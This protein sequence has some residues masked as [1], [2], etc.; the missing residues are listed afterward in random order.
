MAETKGIDAQVMGTPVM[1]DVI[2][3]VP[4][5]AEDDRGANWLTDFGGLVRSPPA[6]MWHVAL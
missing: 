5:M 4:V 2:M 6:C 3:G 1:G